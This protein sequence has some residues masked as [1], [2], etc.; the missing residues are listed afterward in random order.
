MWI[1]AVLCALLCLTA[2]CG[3]S[4]NASP[5]SSSEPPPGQQPPPPPNT[6]GPWPLADLTSYGSAQNLNGTIIDASPDD[7]QNIWAVTPDALYVLHPGQT[8]FRR[9]T[10]ADGLHVQT[11]TDPGTGRQTV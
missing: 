5:S 1:R 4:D 10:A 7:A 2:A 6:A 3:G 8:A 11:Y 9:F